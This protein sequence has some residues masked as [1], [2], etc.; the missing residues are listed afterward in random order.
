[1]SDSCTVCGSS[2]IELDISAVGRML[3]HVGMYTWSYKSA[4]YIETVPGL[5]PVEVVYNSYD[6]NTGDGN[7]LFVWKT[8]AGHVSVTGTYDSYSDLE[9]NDDFKF[10]TPETKQ[11]TVYV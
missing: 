2:L 11:I 8:R 3:T 4:G 1:M 5:G 10:V 6:L 9:W 7:M